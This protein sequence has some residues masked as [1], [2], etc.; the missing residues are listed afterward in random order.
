MADGDPRDQIARLEADMEQLAEGLD[1]CRK[2]ILLSKVAIAA[3]GVLLLGYFL[4][5]IGFDPAVMIGAL[6]AVIGGV[7]VLGSNTTTSKQIGAAMKAAEAR[8]GEL[9]DMIGLRTVGASRS[10]PSGR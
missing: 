7:V 3:G 1:R 6:A 10:K 8:R 5:A 2:A 4:G 9:V